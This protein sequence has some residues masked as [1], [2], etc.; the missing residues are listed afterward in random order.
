MYLEGPLPVTLNNAL[1]FY[2]E[3]S[4]ETASELISS[5]ILWLGLDFSAESSSCGLHLEI[6]MPPDTPDT[7]ER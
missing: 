3:L 2:S 1:D 6:H 5:E 7:A 4:Y